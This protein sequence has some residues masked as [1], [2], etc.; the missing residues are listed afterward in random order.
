MAAMVLGRKSEPGES[1]GRAVAV[2]CATRETSRRRDVR[3][4][5]SRLSSPYL[6]LHGS[7]ML[8]DFAFGAIG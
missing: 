3:D 2:A 5:E 4:H 7:W 8:N 6:T 1:N